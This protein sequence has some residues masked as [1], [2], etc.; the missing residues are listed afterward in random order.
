[1]NPAG[2]RHHV[3]RL[4]RGRD[5][6]WVYA[7]IVIV[8]SIA[9]AVQP[10]HLADQF[11][12]GSSTNLVNLRQRPLSVLFA[13][14][15]VTYPATGLWLVAP[16][17]VAYGALQRWLGRLSV[18]VVAAAGHV[19]ATLLVATI[20]LTS[21]TRGLV[22]FSVT[23]RPDVGISYGLLAVAG[24]LGA[25]IEPRWRRRYL[26]AGS[27][28]IVAQA[29]LLHDFT[30]LGHVVAWLIGVALAVPVVRAVGARGTSPLP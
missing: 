29:F 1:M 8:I 17:V 25:R 27:I 6:A 22:G 20:E 7:A 15:F 3:R 16:M 14:P 26:L 18:L 13:S 5:V 21:V 2:L 19:G 12:N 10:A 30:A 28:A 11:V 24:F 9:V 23:V 4:W